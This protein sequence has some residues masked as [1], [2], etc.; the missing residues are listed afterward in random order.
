MNDFR[1]QGSALLLDGEPMASSAPKRSSSTIY[2]IQYLRAI[3]AFAV[4]LCHASYYVKDIRGDG[5][6]WEI[7]DRAGY[8]G[9]VLFFAISGYLMARLAENSTGL[10]FLA[11]R[12]IRIYPIYWLC[13][14]S[15]LLVEW[16]FRQSVG[17]D[18]AA[19][20]LIPGARSYVLGVEWTLPFE[21]TFYSIVFGIIVVGMRRA[22]PT[23]ALVWIALMEVIYW[24][25]PELQRGQFPALLH[26]PIDLYSMPF[27]SGLLVPYVLR[28]GLIGPA[29]PLIGIGLLVAYEA[30]KPISL[31][32]SS[33]FAGIGSMLLVAYAVHVG[34]TRPSAP[35]RPLAALGDWSY[36]LYLIHVPIIR[37]L[38][39]V[40]P[41]SVPTMQL[42]F[43]AAGIPVIACILFG[44]I[45]LAMYRAL[46][47][48]VDR[49]GRKSLMLLAVAFVGMLLLFSGYAYVKMVR[50]Y[51]ANEKMA[52]L[53][54]RIEALAGGAPDTAA[55][56]RAVEQAGYKAD[57]ALKGHFD[58]IY[59]GQDE[60]RVQG[61]AADINKGI[62]G[63]RA[64]QVL[65]F[66]CG[67]TLG[68]ANLGESRSDV[69]RVWGISNSS[70]GFNQSL[71]ENHPCGANEAN[72]LILTADNRYGLMSGQ[73][74]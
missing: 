71:Q 45:D 37:A 68:L 67:R 53:A 72:A 48:R 33:A 61:W 6:M 49:V 24:W 9:V 13:I 21:L 47:V 3:A 50:A 25:R 43:A 26:L 60:I 1:L 5:R 69:A 51:V 66:F 31:G 54:A 73:V 32:L 74:H 57:D 16:L 44:K 7:F 58:G 22:I 2:P 23:I 62:G 10:R 39:Y 34:T 30:M 46:K 29:T 18:H 15:V 63:E 20:L 8:L 4:V 11:H 28:K 56:G 36:A 52:P 64:V 59:R 27:A 40:M 17:I 35:I 38:C 70:S 65:V 19:L 42:W 12:L 41:V 55:L 14:F